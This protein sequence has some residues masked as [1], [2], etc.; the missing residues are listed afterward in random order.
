[1]RVSLRYIYKYGSYT[2]VNMR[3]HS[4]PMSESC[5]GSR[6]LSCVCVCV[7]CSPSS[8]TDG[9]RS[10]FCK[11]RVR[12]PPPQHPHPT[13]P[14]PPNTRLTHG[15]AWCREDEKRVSTSQEASPL[16]TSSTDSGRRGILCCPFGNLSSPTSKGLAFWVVSTQVHDS[17]NYFRHSGINLNLYWL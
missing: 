13:P 2:N 3:F 5:A 7:Y 14:H 17:E 4:V 16:L 6:S 10:N 15:S 1:M 8:W 12:P 11:Q 9:F